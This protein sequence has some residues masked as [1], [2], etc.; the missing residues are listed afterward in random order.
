M[1]N[2]ILGKCSGIAKHNNFNA[3][4]KDVWPIIGIVGVA[5]GMGAGTAAYTC[6]R[7]GTDWKF[8]KVRDYDYQGQ[9]QKAKS[10]GIEAAK[11]LSAENKK[12]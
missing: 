6:T 3:F 1:M 2:K 7:P 11:Y 5:L 12:K 9:L 4:P 8:N 10:L